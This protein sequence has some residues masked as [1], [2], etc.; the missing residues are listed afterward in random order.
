MVITRP[1]ILRA[2][3]VVFCGFKG[4]KKMKKI[5]IITTLML[6]SFNALAVEVGD[7]YYH[8]KSFST[9]VETAKM[10]IGVVYWV[11]IDRTTGYVL[12][13][14]QPADMD[15][16]TA[17]TQ[18]ANFSTLGTNAGNWKLPTM[19]QAFKM[20]TQRWNGVID[21]KFSVI[22]RKLSKITT[23]QALKS[24]NYWTLGYRNKWSVNPSSGDFT[25]NS[26]N[27]GNRAVRCVMEVSLT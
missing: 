13:L 14:L 4:G 1:R 26:G 23:G 16:A 19:E 7:V 3:T 5:L 9:E 11:N 21:Q 12:A 27:T 17:K 24:G 18:C 25:Y 8:D 15:L 2:C 22:N 20:V 6:W 10:P